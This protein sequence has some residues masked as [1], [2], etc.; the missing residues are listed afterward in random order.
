MGGGN[1]LFH[2]VV[3]IAVG[4]YRLP[5]LDDFTDYTGFLLPPFYD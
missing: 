4:Y 3:R 5:N 2:Y 1:H